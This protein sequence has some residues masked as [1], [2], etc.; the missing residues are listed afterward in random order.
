MRSRS[1]LE[2]SLFGFYYLLQKYSYPLQN[3]I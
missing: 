2:S 3:R 1:L